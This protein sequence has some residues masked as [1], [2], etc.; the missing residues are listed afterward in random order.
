VRA[1]PTLACLALAAA[2]FPGGAMALQTATRD[3]PDWEDP[4]VV[5][6]G[7]EP[8]RASFL[9]FESRD[10]A[11]AGDRTASAYFRLL[12][13]L[14]RFHWVERPSD[15]PVDFFREEYDA[16][17]WNL[18]PVPSNWEIQG[19]GVPIYLN[20][21]YEFEKNPP[22]IHHDHNPVGSF[23]T[24]FRIPNEWVGRAIFL[25]FGAVKSAMYV[26][27]N[28]QRVGYSQDSKLP[29]EFDITGFVRAGENL[30]A[31]EVYRWSDGSYL[32]CQDF[33]RVSGIERDVFLWAAPKLH[34]RDFFVRA[35]LDDGYRRG[36]LEVDLDLRNLGAAGEDRAKVHAELL[37]P[38]TGRT[39][40][41]NRIE[42]GLL[43]PGQEVTL[44]FLADVGEVSPWT[45]ETPAL[46]PLLLTLVDA[47]GDTLQVLRQSVGFREVEVRDG[48][49]RVNG[50]PVTI[51]GVNRHEHDPYT[52][53]VI[54]EASMLED[55]RLMKAA[56][57]NAVRTSHY[58]ND[59]LW[60]E[61]ADRYGLYVVDEANIESHG[62]GYDPDITLGNNPAWELAH[63]DRVHRMVERDKNH[64]SVIIW[65]LGNEAGN[66]VNFYK[67]Y[68]WAK[69]RD[70]TRPVQYERA[71][72]DWNTDIYVPMYAGFEHLERY[73]RSDPGRPLI[74]CEYAHAMGN[75]VGNFADYWEIIDRHPSLQGGFIWDWVDQGLFKV[76]EAGDS[77]WAYGGDF[78]PPGTPSDGN[79]LINGLV[80]PDRLPNPH[81][82]EVKRVY[83]WIRLEPVA[84]ENGRVRVTNAYD[85]R[86]L[87]GL[88]LRWRVLEDGEVRQEGALPVP[89]V[90]PG[91]ATDVR[92]PF[93]RFGPVPGAEYHLD[94]GI[95]T[96]K[97]GDLLEAGHEVASHQFALPFS[98]PGAF[99]D[100]GLLPP[101]EVEAGSRLITVKGPEFALELDRAYGRISSY[102]YR[103]IQLLRSG[104]RPNFWR[105]PTDNDYGGGW[106]QKLGVW[107]DAGHRM[108]V[109]DT[110]YH[111]ISPQAVEIAV[112]GLLPSAGRASYETVYTVLGN[113]EVT[114]DVRF[115]PGR[116]SLPRMPRFGM[117][118]EM[119]GEFQ[120]LA[121]F[122]R[123]PEESY[124]DRNTAARAGLFRGM[125]SEQYHPYV[126]PQETGNKTDVRWMALEREDGVGLLIMAGGGEGPLGA[127]M[128]PQLHPGAPRVSVP[129]LSASALH[130]TQEDLDDGPSKSQRHA[131][132][133][134]PRS[135]VA[136][137]VDLMQMGVG[138]INSWGPT[139]LG[140]YS[141]PYGHYRYR[142]T[143]RP[144]AAAEAAP[145]ELA[146]VRFRPGQAP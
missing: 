67:A 41:R 44:S 9:P 132:E 125:V 110:D 11:L 88:E 39:I 79:F 81:Y 122:G 69:E 18:I 87:E 43:G 123:G 55:I 50:V 19:Y 35:G 117:R 112:R 21:P 28:G 78:G 52:G 145:G 71:L 99:S 93:S 72:Q 133:L 8:P 109:L 1:L 86:S 66:G 111:R 45:A 4:S 107:K 2:G 114:V 57:M 113:G 100:P 37:D 128:D 42:S 48:L 62:M 5:G 94:L 116:D 142:Y 139:A 16:A 36:R 105:A 119:P 141:L 138:G 20:H 136:V 102:Q 118:F 95:H 34:I 108:E 80:Q 96:T 49:L 115:E 73:A 85:F 106:Q 97:A 144:F 38:V 64:P 74:L 137:N 56:N 33:W 91:E 53:H 131:G 13:G 15:R 10:L 59:P 90:G 127:G 3:V 140:E 76:T 68:E 70:T 101:L 104:P 6:I 12:N 61:L 30:L 7:K 75:S 23:R 54:S 121:W 129:H 98:A 124:W 120:R 46:Y 47:S 84:L 126:R 65:S 143:L 27:V 63:V 58:P 51:K 60:Y 24:T 17:G 146:R 32:E 103:G 82:W 40:A 22:F 134:R 29:A 25:H 31:V 89:G 92:I 77:I 135:L 130:F 26:W 83:Q 14:W